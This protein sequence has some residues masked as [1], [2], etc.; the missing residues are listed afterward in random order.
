MT[1]YNPN[2]HQRHSIRLREYDYSKAG[3]YFVTVCTQNRECLF[4]NI[5]DGKIKLNDAG[6][7]VE[8]WWVEL[9]HKYQAI[10]TDVY[11]V[12]PNH[13]HG[14]IMIVGATLRGRPYES[15]NQKKGNQIGGATT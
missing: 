2:M 15:C 12:M 3:A 1:R 14:I 8:K 11:V 13:F 5:V 6:R 9:T 10:E 7:M 4:G